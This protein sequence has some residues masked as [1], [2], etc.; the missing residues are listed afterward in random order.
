[1][2]ILYMIFLQSPSPELLFVIAWHSRRLALCK[3]L[4]N[5]RFTT[6]AS[7]RISLS[8]VGCAEELSRQK[9]EALYC[10][11]PKSDKF[12]GKQAL[13]ITNCNLELFLGVDSVAPRL[14]FLTL[15]ISAQETPRT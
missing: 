9:L 13:D 12:P 8:E 4:R 15:K 5:L 2:G 1:M 3:N 10:N 11:R 6:E 14:V 7:L